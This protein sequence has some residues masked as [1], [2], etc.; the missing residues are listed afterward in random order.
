[1][2]PRVREDDVEEGG[3]IKNQQFLWNSQDAKRLN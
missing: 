2:D 1:M 3:L